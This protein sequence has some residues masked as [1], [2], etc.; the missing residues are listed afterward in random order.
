MSP[1]QVQRKNH[2]D[3]SDIKK[4]LENELIHEVPINRVDFKVEL[5]KRLKTEAD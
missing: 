2:H 5:K 1:G 3:Y 4:Q